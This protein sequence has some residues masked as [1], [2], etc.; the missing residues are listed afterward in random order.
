M[1][2]RKSI[3]LALIPTVII[4][5]TSC[6]KGTDSPFEFEKKAM[7]IGCESSGVFGG[8]TF[9]RYIVFEIT[10]NTGPD[11]EMVDDGNTE[12]SNADFNSEVSNYN[13]AFDLVDKGGNKL[14]SSSKIE[15]SK[16]KL[17][18]LK[19]S[20]QKYLCS[21]I[22]KIRMIP[23]DKRGYQSMVLQFFMQ[24]IFQCP[25]SHPMNENDFRLTVCDGFIQVFFKY[26]NLCA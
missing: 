4:F 22:P 15:Y 21:S 8:G 13:F 2:L 9:F 1:K 17:Y 10:K 3:G 25:F 23:V 12:V 18:L 11:I 14:A 19:N 7:V 6:G 5:L 20:F 24:D 26:T 16:W